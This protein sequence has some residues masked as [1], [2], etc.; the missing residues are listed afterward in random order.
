MIISAV[1]ILSFS[2]FGFEVLLTRFFS[3]TQWNHLSFMVISLVLFGFAAGGTLLNILDTRLRVWKNSLFSSRSIMIFIFLYVLTSIGAFTFIN[4]IPLDY[5]RLPFEPV[6]F[7]Y[8]CSTYLVLSLPF[9]ITG[10]MI[11]M[12]YAVIP[13]KTGYIYAA[14]MAGSA[15]GAA[16]PVPALGFLNEG[17]LIL[18]I[19]TVPL[20]IL[21]FFSSGKRDQKKIPLPAAV[22][23]A[24]VIPAAMIFIT[25]ITK[26]GDIKPSAYKSLSRTL[27]YPDTRISES[28]YSIRGRT[29]LVSSPYIR[30]APGL[31]LKYTDK[32]PDQRAVFRDGDHRFVLYDPSGGNDFSFAKS[33]LSYFGYNLNN[34]HENVLI[35]QKGGGLA[36][37]CAAASGAR[38]ITVVEQNPVL[39]KIISKAYRFKTV[40]MNHQVFLAKSKSL[41]DIIHIE[42]WGTSLIGSTSLT[43]EYSFTINAFKRYYKHLTENGII[44]ISRK[45]LLP[46]SDSVRM[47][48]SAYESLRAL[49]VRD[50]AHHI[51]ILR[52]WD[53]FTMLITARPSQNFTSLKTLADQLNFDIVYCHGMSKDT[54]NRYHV[55][56]SPF[57]YLEIE[58]LAKAYQE[59]AGKRYFQYS[60]LDIKPQ[61]DNRPFPSRFLK[62]S[63]IDE[64]YRSLGDRFYSLYLSGEIIISIVFVQAI[65]ISAIFLVLPAVVNRKKTSVIPVSAMIYFFSIGAGFIFL[66]LFFL[67]T[68]ILLF[69]NPTI[70]FIIACSGIMVFSSVGGLISMR[71]DPKHLRMILIGLTGILFILLF[72]HQSLIHMFLN[73]SVPMQYFAAFLLMAPCSIL[74]GFP[75][76]I[77]MQYFLK[78]PSQRTYAWALNGCASVLTCIISAQIAISIGIS[79]ILI[80]GM[81]SYLVA[82]IFC[83]TSYNKD[84]QLVQTELVSP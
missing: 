63:R 18:I 77:G 76:P 33:T 17:Q 42:N 52:N 29:D 68:F 80:F 35:I 36:I 84:G 10:L 82:I 69:D 74:L 11:S 8:L 3:I 16:F 24:A 39:S 50:P 56:D 53:T 14:S 5:F 12:S 41:Y 22:L 27:L 4:N 49:H 61:T 65:C 30:F 67:K 75:F 15:I 20:I 46:P 66:E 81:T 34:G 71:S 48:A 37:P 78:L 55:Y 83:K 25:D 51:I 58:K 19:S 32:L 7:F 70:S 62:W 59:G 44:I 1:F 28:S 6:Q 54:A 21:P 60:F 43:Q 31:S 64:L 2:S 72:T 9:L 40:N 47:W 26:F 13:E 23:L 57:H 45:L 79:M 38:N 73:L